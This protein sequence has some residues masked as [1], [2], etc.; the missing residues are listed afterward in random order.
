[1]VPTEFS[2]AMGIK[3]IEVKM[4]NWN[5]QPAVAIIGLISMV[6]LKSGWC[7]TFI[8]LLILDLFNLS[9]VLTHL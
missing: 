2:T 8:S 4:E 5:F 1:M 6:K 9:S 3:L 7:C